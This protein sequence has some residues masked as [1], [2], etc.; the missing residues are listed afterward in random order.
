LVNVNL[1]CVGKIKEK[2]IENGMAEFVKRMKPYA[3]L[4]IIELKE[5]G[6]DKNRESSIDKESDEIIRVIEKHRGYTILM[7]VNGR[8]FSSEGMAE[9]I[10]NLTVTG[11]STLNFIIGGSYGVS[12]KLKNVVDL[13]MSFSD[14]TFPHQLMRLI[15]LEQ[16]YRWFSILNNGKYHK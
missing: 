14:L 7:D 10:E 4:S 16:L 11:S 12:D 13:K 8:K 6:N 3:K 2:Y 1:V 9:K 15:F 5:D